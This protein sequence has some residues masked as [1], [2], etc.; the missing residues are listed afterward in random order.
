MSRHIATGCGTT[1]ARTSK[2]KH[3]ALRRNLRQAARTP[4]PSA[5]R[6]PASSHHAADAILSAHSAPFTAASGPSPAAVPAVP[7][8]TAVRSTTARTSPHRQSRPDATGAR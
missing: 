8:T 7:S 1:Q 6:T 2:A 3:A 5:N 4:A